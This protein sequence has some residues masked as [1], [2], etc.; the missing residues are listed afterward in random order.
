MEWTLRRY[1]EYEQW[2]R[3]TAAA[4]S[5]PARREFALETIRHIH[6]AAA[7]LVKEEFNKCEQQLLAKSLAE[8]EADSP[9]ES[10][11]VLR[12]LEESTSRDE[13][14]AIEFHPKIIWLLSAIEDWAKYRHSRDPRL[15]ADM[16]MQMVNCLDCDAEI[17][18]T[19]ILATPQMVAEIDRQRRLLG[20]G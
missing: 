16:A 18:I 12:S 19:N 8:I 4:A 6:H 15:I 17:D 5:V 14:R 1:K 11:S 7:A 9:T 3:Q 10:L 2:I 20:S 13:V